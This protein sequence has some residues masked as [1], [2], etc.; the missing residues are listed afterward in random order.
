MRTLTANQRLTALV[1]ATAGP[2]VAYWQQHGVDPSGI[3]PQ[4]LNQ[5]VAQLVDR[6]TKMEAL[7]SNPEQLSSYFLQLDADHQQRDP[8]YGQYAQQWEQVR[9]MVEYLMQQPAMLQ[10]VMQ[11]I[12]G[13]GQQQQQQ[14]PPVRQGFPAPTSAPMQAGNFLG[15]LEGIHPAKRW[16]AIRSTDI[17]QLLG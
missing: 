6:T 15:S 10:A 4:N 11:M 14:A 5:A 7:L 3:N 9:Q 17:S 2:V 8:N 12:Q 13:Q 1:Q 16:Q